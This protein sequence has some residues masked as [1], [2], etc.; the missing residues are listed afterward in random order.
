MATQDQ[1]RRIVVGVD[2]SE[3]ATA[4]LEW[5]ALM[6]KGFG[7]E[8]VAVFA[9]SPPVY[10]DTGFSA[11]TIPVEYDDAWRAEIKKEFEQDWV[12]P[13]R[14]AGVKYRTE[15]TDGRAASVISQVADAEEADMVVVGRRG[16]GEVAE[17]LLGSVSHELVLHSKR[18]ILVISTRPASNMS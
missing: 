1:I 2:G 3:Q 11:P 17:L 16:R 6:A 10:F 9:I 4:A 18:P 7:S 14:D 12:K 8:V 13:L 15:I 5:A